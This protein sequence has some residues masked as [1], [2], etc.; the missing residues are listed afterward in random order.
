VLR[1]ARDPAVDEHDLSSVEVAVSGAAPLPANVAEEFSRRIGCYVKQGYGMTELSPVAHMHP[2]DEA[3]VRPGTVGVIHPN[4]L[5]RLVDPATGGDA[6]EGGHGEVWGKG[7]QV[8]TGD[9]D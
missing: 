4:T 3:A 8:L 9:L 5:V 7:P 6:P 2:D 1:L